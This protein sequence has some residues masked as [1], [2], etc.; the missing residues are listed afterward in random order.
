M[1]TDT[2]LRRLIL[3]ADDF[4]LAPGVDDA[5]IDLIGKGRLSATSVMVLPP[6][7]SAAEAARLAA[8]AEGRAS[9]GLHVTL[10]APFQPLTSGFGPLAGDGSFLPIGKLLAASFVTP[11]DR[12]A[13]AREVAAQMA[14][15]VTA[16]G[17]PP[18]YVDGHQHVHL[19]PGMREAV[20][21]VV[22]RAAP[23]AW[24]RQCGQVTATLKRLG[25]PKSLLL[26]RM[27]HA[28]RRLAAER[29][30][31]TNPAFAG[32]YTFKPGV[33]Y[34]T[35]FPAFLKD[36]PD[37]SVVMCHPGRVDTEL[38]RLDPLTDLREAEYAYLGGEAFP[39]V[40][41][42]AGFTLA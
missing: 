25:D 12:D 26:D 14:A 1:T 18:A 32:T 3:C 16:F 34:A 41:A 2:P 38:K 4:G 27:S 20:L 39:A 40:L 23:Q 10:T 13:I 8:V 24:V 30:V 22:T 36:L 15:F 19:L 28:F 42:R 29:G 33:D 31:P 7:F 9:V 5:I 21:D 11:F 37:G 17:R 6:T 35:L